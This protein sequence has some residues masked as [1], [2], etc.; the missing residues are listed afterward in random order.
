[1]GKYNCKTYQSLIEALGFLSAPVWHKIVE[2]IEPT[3]L[4]H[5]QIIMN[6][7][8]MITKC[9]HTGATRLTPKPV[10]LYLF[11]DQLKKKKLYSELEF[12]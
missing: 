5:L 12:N 1:M 8:V 4:P 11:D 9:N 3:N 7:A 6:Y 10:L 2:I